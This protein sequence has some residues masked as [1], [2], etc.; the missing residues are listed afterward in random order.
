M[1]LKL[2]C[3]LTPRDYVQAQFLHLRPRPAFKW[4]GLVLIGLTL[5]VCGYGFLN[6]SES[7]AQW[8]PFAILA[9]LLYF[10]LF[11]G[12]WLPFRTK[13]LFSQQKTLQ[14]PYE[15][16]I[17]DDALFASDSHGQTTMVWKD[18]HKYKTGERLIL[19]YQ[20]DALFHMFPIRWFSE[21]QFAEFREL[22]RTNLG[23][24]KP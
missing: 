11:Y 16:E 6:L 8:A 21:D 14:E 7:D 23:E 20:S 1:I 3:Q 4:I 5:V 22:L 15:V 12:V 2:Q 10:A 19:L 17:S 9:T 13:R 18:F 24:P